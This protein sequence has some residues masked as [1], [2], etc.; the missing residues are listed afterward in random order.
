MEI[1]SQA[2]LISPA[3]Y[4]NIPLCL[5]LF[6][7]CWNNSFSLFP[8]PGQGQ[9]GGGAHWTAVASGTPRSR[10]LPGAGNGTHAFH[11]GTFLPLIRSAVMQG[12]VALTK[13]QEINPHMH[14]G[15][16][17]SHGWISDTERKWPWPK[18]C[19]TSWLQLQGALHLTQRVASL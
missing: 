3:V 15:S 12:E 13:H 17:W 16:N 18:L 4:L 9:G 19:C 2:L 5:S 8:G 10:L 11:Q 14:T 1:Y 7:L 6:H